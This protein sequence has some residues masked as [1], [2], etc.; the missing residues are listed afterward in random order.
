VDQTQ[1]ASQA[2]Q[3]VEA[4]PN[5]GQPDPGYRSPNEIV[6][7]KAQKQRV[8]AGEIVF[9]P[10]RSPG[11]Y[12]EEDT[13]LAAKNDVKDD[14]QTVHVCP[15]ESAKGGQLPVLLILP[16]AAPKVY[17]LATNGAGGGSG[18]IKLE[19]QMGAPPARAERL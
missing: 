5:I 7:G 4:Q 11:E 1:L 18:G 3:F 14:Q 2:P 13:N 19:R 9:A 17:L 16:D 12:E 10:E 15:G 8:V 6:S